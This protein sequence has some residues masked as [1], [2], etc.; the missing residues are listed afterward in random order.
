MTPELETPRLRLRAFTEA[1]LSR[2]VDL[3]GRREIADTMISVPHPY[4]EDRARQWL[5]HARAEEYRGQSVHFAICQGAGDRLVGAIELRAID[6]EHQQAEL[7]FWLGI[8]CWGQGYASEAAAWVLRHGFGHR[9]LNRIYA[10][11]ML[12]NPASGA[13]LAKL[14]LCREAVLRQRVCKWGVFEDV[15]RWAILREDWA[16]RR[17]RSGPA[18]IF[19]PL[20]ST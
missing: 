13:V 10:H 3:A 6:R 2:L 17:R 8:D 18:A 4:T 15:A 7:S 19:R 5:A 14:G 1:D 11:H 12:R 16:C 20:Q 9:H